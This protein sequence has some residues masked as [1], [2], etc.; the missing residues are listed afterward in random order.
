MGLETK[1]QA[2]NKH[3]AETRWTNKHNAE[4]RWTCVRDALAWD[5]G[6]VVVPATF[7]HMD[8]R[9]LLGGV[10]GERGDGEGGRGGC[11]REA[12]EPLSV[13]PDREGE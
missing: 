3:N 1:K 9:E 2:A 5:C 10:D 6:T 12:V 4:T 13:P 8:K 7:D 11:R